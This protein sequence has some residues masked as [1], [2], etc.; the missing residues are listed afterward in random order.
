MEPKLGN[1]DN[2]IGAWRLSDA[3]T[4]CFDVFQQSHTTVA[5]PRRCPEYE[6]A[7]TDLT[8]LFKSSVGLELYVLPRYRW[9][10]PTKTQRSLS[11]RDPCSAATF[12]RE[13]TQYFVLVFMVFLK[14][15]S[16]NSYI[17]CVFSVFF[18]E[19][20]KI[21]DFSRRKLLRRRVTL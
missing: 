12:R 14:K 17:F 13:K 20:H 8:Q 7:A 9:V 21:L 4:R 18:C 11:I 19:N 2:L 6:M 1:V 10:P 16:I 5:T 15:I 3:L